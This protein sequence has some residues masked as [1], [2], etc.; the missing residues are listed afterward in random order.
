MAVVDEREQRPAR[1]HPLDPLSASEIR[2]ATAL[3]REAA[4]GGAEPRFVAVTLSEPSK[5]EL[6]GPGADVERRAEVIVYDPLD[7]QIHET[8]ISLSEG[9]ILETREVQ[10]AHAPFLVGEWEPFVDAVKADA[11]YQEALARRGITNLDLISIDP[12]PHGLWEGDDGAHRLCRAS[13]FLRSRPG[14]N[15]HA[16]HVEG[17]V[18]VVDLDAMA[19]VAVDDHGIVDLPPDPGEYDATAVGPL[20]D[21]LRPLEVEQQ[22]GP[23]FSVD[24]WEVTWQNWR[25][26]VG[27]NQ[28]E[29][30]VLHQLGYEDAGS[31]RTILHRAS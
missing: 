28:R 24:G 20:R 17:L 4:I 11:R 18:C 1:R 14:G 2:A 13:S 29:G 7:H 12:I 10:G 31:E 30:L 27:F 9:V 3:V 6:S 26:R 21:D 22:E 19:V 23:S 5:D 16:R 8:D 15:R 25:F